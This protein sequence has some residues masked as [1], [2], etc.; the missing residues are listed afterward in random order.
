MKGNTKKKDQEEKPKVKLKVRKT[1]KKQPNELH[2]SWKRML[3]N[4]TNLSIFEPYIVQ[5]NVS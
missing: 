2:N 1:K 3:L 4:S 5:S